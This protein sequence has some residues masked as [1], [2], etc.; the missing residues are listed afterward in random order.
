MDK[1]NARTEEQI[2]RDMHRELRAW[3]EEVPESPDRMDPLL[4]LL[5]KLYSSQ[6]ATIDSRIKDTWKAASSALIRSICPE[7]MRFPV[8]AYTVMQAEC[9]DPAV[10]VDPDT[11]YFYKEE[12][13]GGDT[14]FFSSLKDEKILGARVMKLYF[15]SGG[16]VYDI[17]P[18][19]PGSTRVS[20]SPQSSALSGAGAQIYIAI[21]HEGHA[22]D[23]H[24]SS[25]FMRGEEEALKQLQFS[26]WF[27]CIDGGFDEEGGFCPGLQ[28]ASG[29]LFSPD[30]TMLDWGGLRRSRDLFKP[31]ENSF[32]PISGD[33]ATAW[34]QGSPDADFLGMM[35][36]SGMEIPERAGKLFWIKVLLPGGGDKTVFRKPFRLDFNCFL[37]VNKQARTLFKH[38]GGNRLVEIEIPDGIEEIVKIVSVS[39]SQ[40]NDFVPRYEALSGKADNFYAL[41]AEGGRLK[42]IFDFSSGIELP[43][44]SITVNYT[45]TNGMDANGISAGK[46]NE[47]YENHPGIESLQNITPVTGAIPAKTDEQIVTEVS[48]RLRGRDRAMSLDQIVNWAVTFDRRILSAR[49]EKGVM[50]GS[51][52]LRKCVIVRL[53][54][55]EKEFYSD[56]E[57]DLLRGRL[58]S[59]L[60]GRT[61][62]NSQFKVEVD[63]SR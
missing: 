31:L 37:A 43:P 32:V 29:D 38:T 15:V 57:I 34:R 25:I 22:D 52:G 62:I 63:S 36:S 17:S 19:E 60:K 21:E 47:L 56:D 48:N 16:K 6:L 26:K 4:R 42:L 7:G 23:F 40:G 8:P 50:K 30:D 53:E 24:D 9:S 46:I 5:M 59:F 2:F 49:C 28:A 54:V 51:D 55:K 11:S 10:I 58:E 14:F 18:V 13:E 3:N 1:E 44:E 20:S 45:V 12:R 35:K 41:L 39:D 61:S 27:P 33:F